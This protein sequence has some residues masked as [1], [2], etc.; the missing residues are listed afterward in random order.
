MSCVGDEGSHLS[1]A[2]CLWFV[3]SICRFLQRVIECET[4]FLEDHDAEGKEDELTE[5][6]AL[7]D[8]YQVLSSESQSELRMFTVSVLVVIP[9]EGNTRHHK[10]CQICNETQDEEERDDASG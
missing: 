4:T 10:D 3:D 5:Q 9:P 8:K 6:Q 1:N 7:K 2:C